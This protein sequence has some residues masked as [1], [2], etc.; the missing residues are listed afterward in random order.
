MTLFETYIE[1]VLA[2]QQEPQIGDEFDFELREQM[3]VECRIVAKYVNAIVVETNKETDALLESYGIVL[4]DIKRY[5]AV[6][7]NRGMGYSLSEGVM[8]EIAI[9]LGEIADRE[10]FDALYD[11]MTST[12]PA[13]QMVQEIANDIAVEHRLYDDDHEE[14]LERVMDYLV[15]EFGDQLDEAEYQGRDVDLNKPTRGD[16]KKFKVYVKDPSTGNVKKVNFGDPN[17]RIKKSD[18]DRRR[19]FRARHRCDT[20]KDK[21]TARYWSC[22]KW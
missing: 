10:D 11:L 22:R 1:Q 7:S 3:I 8:S 2:E 5:G 21:T 19:S 18:P 13:G 14:L 20:A 15:D 17:M 16:V 12:S 9:E 4:E 6:G